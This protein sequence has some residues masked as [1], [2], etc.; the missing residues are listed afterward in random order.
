M[1]APDITSLIRPLPMLALVLGTSVALAGCSAAGV[2]SSSPQVSSQTVIDKFGH[3][4]STVGPAGEK[5]TP[6]T[7]ITLSPEEV[8]QI[9][10]GNHR[11]AILWHELSAWTQALQDGM[12][13]EFDELGV[14]V[15]ATA[16]AKFDAATQ[17]N[18]I[19]SALATAPE[20][21]L[22]QAVDPAT[23][24]AAYQPAVDAGVK[25]VFAD[26]APNGYTHGRQY[27][28]VM[29]D[30]LYQIG[31]QSAEAMC[32]AVG[33]TGT[34]AIMYYD[35]DFHVTNFRDAV[36]QQSLADTCP[37]VKVVAKEGFSDP[38][39][40]EEIANAI[41]AHHPDLSGIYTSWAV[42]AQGVLS[43]LKGA[44]NTTTKIVTIDLDET[45]ATDLVSKG[46]HTAAIITDEA[47]NYG[48]AM[49]ISAAYALLGKPAPA[50]G[51]ADVITVTKDNIAEGY[52]AWNE[53]VP[54]PVSKAGK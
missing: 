13:A 3:I 24:A 15:T 35:A 1:Q 48:K 7:D 18:Q 54:A 49:A 39:K 47:F 43:A 28:A 32:T 37:N 29:T 8:A 31:T 33:S 38:N 30:D 14:T 10:A 34:V 22:G 19:Q 26:Q 5:P 44:G 9:K 42:P 40:A 11:V 21:I 4:T 16:D 53:P 46:G 50:Y 36:F 45:M 25:L 52:A 6:A 23:G 12:L 20:V 27:Q 51:V 41:L 2:A 17:A